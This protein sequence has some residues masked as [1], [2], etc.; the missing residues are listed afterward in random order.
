MLRRGRLPAV[1]EPRGAVAAHRHRYDRAGRP[2]DKAAFAAASGTPVPIGERDCR[3]PACRFVA[4]GRE[5]FCDAHQQRFRD[6][7]A[8]RPDMTADAYVEHLASIGRVGAP[9]FDM[10]G[11]P[12]IVRLELQYGLQCRQQAGRGQMGPAIFGQVTRWISELGVG[13]VL[14]Q[15]DAFWTRAA[16]ERFRPR[17]RANPLGWVRYVRNARSS[18]AIGRRARTSGRW[19]SGR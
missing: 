11:L 4:V 13:S 6:I 19:T 9:R 1:G 12:D 10:R 14:E 3:L 5:E 8:R 17:V 2:S 18:C 15:S 16:A 7:R